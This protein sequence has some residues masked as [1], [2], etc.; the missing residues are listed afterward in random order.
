MIAA[1]KNEPQQGQ[2]Y[3]YGSDNFNI[4]EHDPF[5]DAALSG[6]G[7][8]RVYVVVRRWRTEQDVG[9]SHSDHKEKI[10]K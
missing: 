2:H 3:R 9:Y 10:F 7:Y 6:Y 1:R 5:Q 4:K 8:E